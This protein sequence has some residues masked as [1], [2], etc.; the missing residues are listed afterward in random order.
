MRYLTLCAFALVFAATPVDAH[1]EALFGPQ[2]AS[3]LSPDRYVTVQVF[4]RRSGVPSE[5]TQETTT[6]L[7]TGFSPAADGRLSFSLVVPF[8]FV[9][10]QGRSGVT[11]GW[12]DIIVGARYRQDLG[13]LKQRI[14][15]RETYVL[16][17]GGVEVP[18]GTM[19][20]RFM[21]GS[22]GA[23][24]AGL[25]SVEVGQFSLVG[26]AYFHRDG[27]VDGLRGGGSRFFGASGAWTPI[28]NMETGRVLSFQLGASHE[29]STRE[30]LDGA[31]LADTGGHAVLVHPTVTIGVNKQVLLFAL[32]SIPVT[33]SWRS[34]MDEQRL[35]VGLGTILTFAH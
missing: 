8:S 26:Y 22:A 20:H 23:I 14:G 3:V 15:A 21:Q 30:H 7:S 32:T 11:R 29:T 17:I 12:E 27:A 35:R 5:R 33:Q 6:V 9:T 25:M 16:G 18:S 13:A 1:H 28:D 19:D 31:A 34:P 10:Q 4:S 24:G 2:S